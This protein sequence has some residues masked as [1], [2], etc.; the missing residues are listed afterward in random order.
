LQVTKR[1]EGEHI[2]TEAVWTL[3]KNEYRRGMQPIL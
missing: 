2:E 3:E 1:V